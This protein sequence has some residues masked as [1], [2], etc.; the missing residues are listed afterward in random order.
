MH[1]STRTHHLHQSSLLGS[2]HGV[3]GAPIEHPIVC[4]GRERWLQ[5]HSNPLAAV[6]MVVTA[7]SNSLTEECAPSECVSH[8]SQGC[9]G[10]R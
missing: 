2:K 1:G 8:A 3:T 5:C 6:G 7:V 9:N 10:R 4:V